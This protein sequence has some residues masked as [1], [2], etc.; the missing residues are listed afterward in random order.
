MSGWQLEPE[1]VRGVLRAV[2]EKRSNLEEVLRKHRTSALVL[3]VSGGGWPVA[4]VPAAL[5]GLLTDQLDRL[6]RMREHID[7]GVVGTSLAISAYEAGQEDMATAFERDTLAAA[8]S[9]NLTP[10]LPYVEP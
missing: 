8:E 9:G 7:A 10:F 4:A 2:E 5:D 1:R 6:T 3:D